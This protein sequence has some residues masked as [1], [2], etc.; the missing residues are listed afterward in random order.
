[1]T[2]PS[3]GPISFNAIN[4]ELGQAGTTT[5]SLGQASYR[6]L[7]GV[8]SGPISLSNFYGKSSAPKYFVGPAG[9]TSGSAMN[10]AY[11]SNITS[12]TNKA[13]PNAPYLCAYSYICPIVKFNNVYYQNLIADVTVVPSV[14]YI[15][16][17]TNGIDWVLRAVPT[18]SGISTNN[19][20]WVGPFATTNYLVMVGRRGAIRST[21]GINWTYSLVDTSNFNLMQFWGY[22]PSVNKIA[23]MP[24]TGSS[25]Q[26]GRTISGNADSFEYGQSLNYTSGI[27]STPNSLFMVRWASTT[28]RSIYQSTNAVNWVSTASHVI[29]V[30][31]SRVNFYD[32]SVNPNLNGRFFTGQWTATIANFANLIPMTAPTNGQRPQNGTI[33]WSASDA[34][35]YAVNA[36]GNGITAS[37]D[38]VAWANTGATFT[39]TLPASCG[40]YVTS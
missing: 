33:C 24:A 1:M 25:T 28:N 39:S 8:A 37:S 40:F 7:A 19:Q 16:S 18:P 32:T 15:A 29:S 6:A 20:I 2:L 4:V 12:M 35:W 11:T 27:I 21:D 30:G 9:K 36:D 26:S 13:Q 17:S 5:A 38:G 14:S 10:S 23:G 31:T 34:K 22:L 3:S